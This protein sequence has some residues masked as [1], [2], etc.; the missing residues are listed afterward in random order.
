MI[1]ERRA[2]IEA[3]ID[4]LKELRRAYLSHYRFLEGKASEEYLSSILADVHQ[5]EAEIMEVKKQL[6]PLMSQRQLRAIEEIP[7]VWADVVRG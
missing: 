5:L 2:P 7:K 1:E 4:S 6:P 3:R